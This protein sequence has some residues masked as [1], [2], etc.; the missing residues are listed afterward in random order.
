MIT[1]KLRG[2]AF[3]VESEQ[4]IKAHE[5]GLKVVNTSVTC[6]Y[7]DLETSTKNPA[8]HGLSVLGYV[9]WVVA[10][11]RPLLFISVPGFIS[12]LIGLVLGLYTLQ[13]CNQSNAL[14]I[15]YAI[16]VSILVIVGAL[17]MLV[18]LLLNVLPRIIKRV[19]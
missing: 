11:R 19:G 9:I 10:E 17:A 1:P 5:S 2:D 13:Y 12:L 15:P 16:I 18:G 4:L 7:D 3:S 14:F 8:T 6:R